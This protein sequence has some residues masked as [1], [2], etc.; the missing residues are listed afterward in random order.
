MWLRLLLRVYIV[1][2][3]VAAVKDPSVDPTWTDIDPS[4]DPTRDPSFDCDSTKDS[5]SCGLQKWIHRTQITK[6]YHVLCDMTYYSHEDYHSHEDMTYYI[7]C[8]GVW[9]EIY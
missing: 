2:V 6:G 3:Y 5:C 7:S 9:S 4:V 8:Y 1:V